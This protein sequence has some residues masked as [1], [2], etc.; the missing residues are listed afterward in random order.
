LTLFFLDLDVP[1]DR[2]AVDLR[3]GRTGEDS[4]EGCGEVVADVARFGSSR[5]VGGIVDAEKSR[6]AGLDDVCSFLGGIAIVSVGSAVSCVV[7]ETEVKGLSSIVAWWTGIRERS[8]QSY[9]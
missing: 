1:D 8:S 4:R 2:E 5:L 3:G 9:D 7:P 6:L